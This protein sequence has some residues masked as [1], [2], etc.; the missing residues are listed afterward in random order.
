MFE[1]N[2]IVT[3]SDGKGILFANHQPNDRTGHMGHALVEYGEGKILAFYPNCSSEDTRWNG[4]SGYGWMEFRRS[5][6]YGETWSQP[7]AE[8]HSKALFDQ[9]CGKTHACEFAVCT[10]AGRIILFYLTCDMNVNGHIW[11]PYFEPHYAF[12][13]DEGNTFTEAKQLFDK[14]GRVYDAIYHE[15]TIYVLFYADPELPGKAHNGEADFLL[16]TSSDNGETFELRSKVGFTSTKNCF[17]GTMVF[18]PENDLLVYTYEDL[19]EH[20][21]KYIISKDRGFTWEN[22][23]RAYFEKK[24][25]NPQIIYYHNRYFIHGRG[26]HPQKYF[27]ALVLY[28]SL[29]GINWDEGIYLRHKQAGAGAYSNNLVVHLP[30]GRERLMIQASHAYEANKTNVIMFFVDADYD[31]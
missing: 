12:S 18:T 9:H 14:R 27:G 28:S 8:P 21:L 2:F 6:D 13:E 22:N 1:D 24:L 25:R 3:P 20:N 30:D 17:Y 11:E 4:H 7:I 15:G 26:G 5:L 16:Y 10:D 19:D 29:D 31:K 23:R